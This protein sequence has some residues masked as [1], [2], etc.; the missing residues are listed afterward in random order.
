MY[1]AAGVGKRQ[2]CNPQ[3][4]D[5]SLAR[6]AVALATSAHFL[7]V[8]WQWWCLG[9]VESRGEL[10]AGLSKPQNA[11]TTW[12]QPTSVFPQ[13]RSSRDR[14]V[15][16]FHSLGSS[17]G[18]SQG[19]STLPKGHLQPQPPHSSALLP[20]PENR[21]TSASRTHITHQCPIAAVLF[22]ESVPV[23]MAY[24]WCLRCSTALFSMATWAV[25]L[26]CPLCSGS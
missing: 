18:G 15:N 23:V 4:H 17:A 2:Y 19:H 25:H 24:H 3:D 8:N 26:H 16:V 5:A 10:P 12:S 7:L 22:T 20:P 11:F 9:R 14:S 6:G 1:V 21:A 13:T